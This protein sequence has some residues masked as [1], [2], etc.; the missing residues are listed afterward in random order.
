MERWGWLAI[1]ATLLVLFAA[2]TAYASKLVVRNQCRTTVWMEQ[3]NVPGAP[4]VARIASGRQRTYRIPA[5]ET[6]EAT[7]WWPKTGC[8]R[9]GENCKVGQSIGP[10]PDGGCAPPIDSKFEATW[11]VGETCE[12][13]FN[14]SMVDGYTLPVAMRPKAKNNIA[15]ACK[16]AA[17]P[18]LS[19][20]NDVCPTDEDLSTGG[21]FP[22]LRHQDLRMRDP[23]SGKVTGCFSPCGKLTYAATFGGHGYQPQDPEAAYYC[24]KG[25][26]DT[27]EVCGAGPVRHTTYAKLIDEAC[28]RQVYGWAYDDANG[29]HSCTGDLTV[30]LTICP[31]Q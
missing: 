2:T 11:C 3:L 21:A 4:K 14:L 29:T 6:V 31:K 16:P 18:S 8:D 27:P 1:G 19:V 5:G 10:C 24:C 7:R 15:A 30:V 26:A 12:T 9:N 20:R 23:V 28:R 17:C 13:F 22:A 25:V